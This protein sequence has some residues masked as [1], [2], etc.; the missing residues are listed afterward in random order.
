MLRVYLISVSGSIYGRSVCGIDICENSLM[1]SF[2]FK[3]TVYC[4][5][6]H[7]LLL[8]RGVY[9]LLELSS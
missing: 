9:Y 5:S 4:T 1:L 8:P 2:Y 3:M 6:E 7:Q